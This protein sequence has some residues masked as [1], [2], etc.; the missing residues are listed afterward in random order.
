MKIWEPFVNFF[1]DIVLIQFILTLVS[2]VFIST[3]NV[4]KILFNLFIYILFIGIYLNLIQLDVIVGFL[5]VLEITIIFCSTIV[6]LF[7]N[8]D[9]SNKYTQNFNSYFKFLFFFIL[10]IFLC[11]HIENT[12]LNMY[13]N[14]ISSDIWEDFYL[15]VGVEYLNDLTSLFYSFYLLNSFAYIVIGVSLFISSLIIINLNKI[16]KSN[17]NFNDLRFF[18]IFDIFKNFI[19]TLYLR[20]QDLTKQNIR[21]SNIK[22]FKKN[23]TKRNATHSSR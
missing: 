3:I 11:I 13:N 4:Y 16:Q 2:T 1:S 21:N 18:G 8:S 15:S 9:L 14:F 23:D 20:K 12:D 6:L 7:L 10:F 5:W 17:K 19:E 22:I